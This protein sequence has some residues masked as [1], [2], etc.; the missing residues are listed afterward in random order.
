M[1]PPTSNNT[2]PASALPEIPRST[3]PLQNPSTSTAHRLLPLRPS[4][5]ELLMLHDPPSIHHRPP[6]PLYTLRA[7]LSSN[8]SS[9][10]ADLMLAHTPS[11]LGIT[12]EGA[13]ATRL[14]GWFAHLEGS[15]SNNDIYKRQRQ[16]EASRRKAGFEPIRDLSSL[17]SLLAPLHPFLLFYPFLEYYISQLERDDGANAAAAALA[18][19]E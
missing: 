5:A 15:T 2:L 9:G 6:A 7:A 11:R 4:A 12:G 19:A 17:R 13:L 14:S 1:S 8:F 3:R 18:L 10:H 16:E